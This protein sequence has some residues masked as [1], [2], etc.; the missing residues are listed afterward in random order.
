MD[1]DKEMKLKE[2]VGKDNLLN[3]FV[4]RV[5]NKLS[6]AY[7]DYRSN[8]DVPINYLLA[9]DLKG[10]GRT[11]LKG[12]AQ[13]MQR[14]ATNPEEMVNYVTPLGMV[15][16]IENVAARE[17]KARPPK[18]VPRMERAPAKSKEEIEAIAQR[19]AP[20][21]TGEFVKG[22][23]GSSNVLGMSKKRFDL[24]KELEHDIRPT[25]TPE[26]F[27]MF[28]YPAHEGNV[29]VGI[30][31]D[32]TPAG[33]AIH[34]VAGKKLARPSAQFGGPEYNLFH[35]EDAWASE[36]GA[37][38]GV[39]NLAMDASHQYGGAPV[40]GVYT[41]MG[42]AAYGHAQHLSDA[43]MMNI[44]RELPNMTKSQIEAFN[45]L[46]KNNPAA[47]DF[48]GIHNPE[49][50]LAQMEGNSAMRK[51][52]H[53]L[54]TTPT[55]TERLGM[56]NGLD[57]I[58]A[59]LVPELRNLETGISGHSV[60]ELDP[61]I[62]ELKPTD[63]A[64]STTYNTRIPRKPGSTI[65]RT[66]VPIPYEL[67]FPDQLLQISKNPAQAPQ[68]FGTL[69]FSGARQIIDPQLIE[70]LGIYRN[71]I[72]KYT[73]K[74]DGGSI[75]SEE[76]L[77][78]SPFM[79][80]GASAGGMDYADYP[81][82]YGLRAFPTEDGYGGEMMPKTSGWAGEIPTMSGDTTMTEF[83]LGGERGEPFMPMIFKGITPEQIK[84]VKEY[85]AGLRDDNDIKVKEVKAA[86]REAADKQAHMHQSAFKDYETLLNQ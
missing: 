10:T 43:L 39:Q 70:E 59:G 47:K 71:M 77:S 83:S 17:M 4:N 46:V 76:M 24:E 37:A 35:P 80:E 42:P 34:E 45:T 65:N 52:F 40:V 21:I 49:I 2:M 18:D 67:Q 63:R 53:N 9:G 41:K 36:F 86:A 28:D 33:V 55:L 75:N 50:A 44:V 20:Q 16:S 56:P 61:S 3:D 29:Q 74:K 73:G 27:S 66:E 26:E 31:G 1:L 7:E 54:A 79:G 22:K 69:Q 58:H 68:P 32:P 78:T 8:P 25:A 81:N 60:V 57:V 19:V 5:G 6:Q 15:G 38:T 13:S 84:I 11:M 62:R 30:F 64:A 48:A 23:T 85:E 51:Q 82:P 72:K 14:L 12:A